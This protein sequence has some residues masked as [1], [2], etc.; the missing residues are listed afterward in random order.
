MARFELTRL[1]RYDDTD[2]LNE[3]RRVAKL[4][5]V[6]QMT[7]AAFDQRSKASSGVIRRRFGGWAEAL[8]RAGLAHRFSG[9]APC[10]FVRKTPEKYSDQ[11]LISELRAVAGRLGTTRLTVAVFNHHA[12]PNAETLRRRFGSW[13][14]A[15]KR[16]GLEVAPLG[17]R[18]SDDHY[19]ENMQ[20]VWEHYGRQPSYGEMNRAPS[21]IPAGAY[22][23]KWG[24]WRKALLAFVDR[25]EQSCDKDTQEKTQDAHPADPGKPQGPPC[26]GRAKALGRQESAM[27]RSIPD[28]MRYKVL[29]RDHFKC[30]LCGASP[31]TNPQCQLHVDHIVPFSRGGKTVESNL[32]T[33]CANCNIGKGS[34][35]EISGQ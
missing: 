31:A 16:A 11:D 10:K 27:R 28:R 33:L 14:D 1:T 2:L 19:Q 13:A 29:K 20:Q 3:L 22:E 9:G 21:R 17:R 25:R 6:P 5:R 26:S 30:A 15:L 35:I 4:I 12:M 24:S 8:C 34:A 32:R 7:Q 23:A 18:Y